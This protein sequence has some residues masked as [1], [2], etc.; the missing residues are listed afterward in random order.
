MLWGISG[1]DK[2]N[3]EISTRT[4]KSHF[5]TGGAGA[6]HIGSM[7]RRMRSSPKDENTLQMTP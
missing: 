1:K 3:D 5:K 4:D 2:H 7:E 6:L